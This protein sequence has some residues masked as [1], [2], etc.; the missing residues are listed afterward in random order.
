MNVNP[1]H[2]KSKQNLSGPYPDASLSSGGE[3]LFDTSCHSFAL[4]YSMHNVS[5]SATLAFL[6]S[7]AVFSLSYSSLQFSPSAADEPRLVSA[8]TSSLLIFSSFILPSL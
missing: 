6:A 4:N 7:S 8:L 1:K 2:Q 3:L 5:Q